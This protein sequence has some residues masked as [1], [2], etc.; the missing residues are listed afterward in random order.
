MSQSSLRTRQLQPRLPAVPSEPQNK[1]IRACRSEESF[2]TLVCAQQTRGG[3][4]GQPAGVSPASFGLTQFLE[5]KPQFSNSAVGALKSQSLI[6]SSHFTSLK[7]EK[8]KKERQNKLFTCIEKCQL[9]RIYLFFSALVNA[10]TSTVAQ[11][12]A[13]E[14]QM[15]CSA[16][17]CLF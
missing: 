9:I 17:Q 1:A 2:A 13:C 11:Q 15:K 14:D 3:H 12:C 8:K 7:R 16:A 10:Q 5:N 6:E 4:R